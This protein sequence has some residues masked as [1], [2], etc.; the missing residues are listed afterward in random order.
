MSDPL[1]AVL[2]R[3]PSGL[4]VLSA[5]RGDELAVM[6]ASWVMQAGFDPPMITVALAQGRMLA[7]WLAEETPFVVSLLADNQRSIVRHF[8][9]P[10]AAG[11]NPFA[12]I[13]IHHIASNIPAPASAVGYLICQPVSHVDSADHRI[14]LA[15]VVEAQSGRGGKPMVHIRKNGLTY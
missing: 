13:E 8:S 7:D 2:G 6:L 5:R 11:A 15:R 12:G 3:V 14:F 9:K 1:A 4:F 10:P